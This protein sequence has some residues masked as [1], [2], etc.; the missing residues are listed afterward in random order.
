MKTKTIFSLILI[1]SMICFFSSCG[2]FNHLKQDVL[3]THLLCGYTDIE[4]I[5]SLDEWAR[6]FL[7]RS[8]ER[9]KIS[10]RIVELIDQEE[11]L[12]K[13]VQVWEE[14]PAYSPFREVLERQMIFVLRSADLKRPPYWMKKLA[15]NPKKIPEFLVSEFNEKLSE[16]ELFE[17]LNES[18]K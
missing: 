1:I 10:K 4:H 15:N 9:E 8:S 11:N 5:I 16:I 13:M 2:I 14:L 3:S 7:L 12:L 18:F 17:K 6:P